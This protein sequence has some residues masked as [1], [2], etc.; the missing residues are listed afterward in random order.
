MSFISYIFGASE[1]SLTSAGTSLGIGAIAGIALTASLAFIAGMSACIYYMIQQNRQRINR[2]IAR[3]NEES[4]EL[5]LELVDA[6]NE[7]RE[8]NDSL[9]RALEQRALLAHRQQQLVQ[10]ERGDVVLASYQGPGFFSSA[11]LAY[12]AETTI[13]APSST[14]T[15][16]HAVPV[17][18]SEQQ[19]VLADISEAQ[20]HFE[21]AMS[22]VLGNQ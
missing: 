8:L 11:P 3:V 6:A 1:I 16:F 5:G 2:Q 14:P 9:E 4:Y 22:T 13:L 15:F 17:N 10:T 21:L 7:A 20:T 18:A 19:S 12:P